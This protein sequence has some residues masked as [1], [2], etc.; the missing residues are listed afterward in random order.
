MRFDRLFLLLP[1]VVAANLYALDLTPSLSISLP[2][3]SSATP[4]AIPLPDIPGQ[5]ES[6]AAHLRDIQSNSAT[7]SISK[8]ISQELPNIDREINARHDESA[9]ILLSAPSLDVLRSLNRDWKNLHETL[10]N[11]THDL[12]RRGDQ[13]QNQVENLSLLRQSW[14]QTLQLAQGTDTPAPTLAHVQSL[15]VSISEAQTV[16]EKRRRQIVNLQNRVSL[17]DARASQA[18]TT[19]QQAREQ[20]LSRLLMKDSPAIWDSE[21]RSHTKAALVLESQASFTG[22]LNALSAYASREPEKFALHI[23]IFGLLAAFLYVLRRK[24]QP[25]VQESTMAR[26]TRILRA[27]LAS[28]LL[29]SILAGTRIY[30]EAPR[31]L[32]AVLGMAALFPAVFILRQLLETYLYPILNALVAFYFIDRLRMIGAALPLV[33]RFLFL[34]ETLGGMLFFIWLL[35]PARWE[36]VPV[37]QRDNLWKA[38]HTGAK[39]AL[40]IFALAFAANVFG[41][42]SLSRLLGNAVLR[43]S[44]LA[45]ILYAALQIL[46]LFV[47]FA[48]RVPPLSHL[49]MI[50]RHREELWQRSRWI[51][52][53]LA[54]GLWILAV[55]EFLAVRSLVFRH[56]RQLWTA[57]LNVGSLSFSLGHIVEFGLTL[58]FSLLLSRFIRFVLEEDVYPRL[59]LARGLPYAISTVLHYVIL[60]FGFVFA[61]GALGLDMTKF[62]ILAGAFGVGLGFGLQTIINNFFSGLILLFERPIKVGDVIQI[63]D[64]TGVVE[65][66]GIRASTIRTMAGAEVIIPNGSLISTNVTNWTFSAHQRTIEM[67]VSVDPAADTQKV[68]QTLIDVAKANPHVAKSPEP[69]VLVVKISAASMDLEL[70]ASTSRV[71][72]WNQV[73]SDLAIAIKV[74]LTKENIGLR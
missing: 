9:K 67:P 22:Q 11:W 25:W 19:V 15:I 3:I 37:A 29:L 8:M 24:T 50:S 71:N 65:R 57:A 16:L 5:A 4:T 1:L 44:Y 72:D 39:V 7:D 59:E 58:W 17:V 51:L 31:L 69:R 30:P 54:L 42:V 36:A 49:G 60:F 41:Y 33:S 32:W 56:A 23:F 27:P 66:I 46:D 20:A 12:Q 40:T 68:I 2:A 70:H 13:L 18:L 53:R 45:V 34:G 26:A 48:L 73:R 6:A 10:S 28:A 43:A 61:L 21:I 47:L 35:R 52:E 55:L 62:T 14:Q 74:A 64:A 38:I 63:A